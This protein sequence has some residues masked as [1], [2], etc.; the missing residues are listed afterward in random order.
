MHIEVLTA[1]QISVLD[2]LKRLELPPAF[3][4]AGG[5]ALALRYGHRR[6]VDFDFFRTD[7]F[8]A[9]ELLAQLDDAFRDVEHLPS[10]SHTVQVRLLGV[11]TTFFR[12]R[13][14]LLEP[15]EPTPWGFG[16]ARNGDLAAM[17]LE[18]I[19]GRGSRK[20]FVDLYW[21]CRQGLR[22]ERVFA[23]FDHKYGTERT[24]HYHR[25]RAI[26]YF[27]DAEQEPMPDMLLP[28]DWNDAK[29]FFEAESTRLLAAGLNE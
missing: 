8:D 24:E 25:L 18:A 12:Y 2:R 3:Y 23:L 9:A 14:S 28:F 17:K 21:L 22:L 27:G 16:L 13:Y 7:A 6:S 20:D 26:G 19:A 29:S 11:S 1:E 15:S 10:G 4:L 5:T